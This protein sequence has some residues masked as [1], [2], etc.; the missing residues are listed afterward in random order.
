MG[1]HYN[2]SQRRV[3]GVGVEVVKLRAIR[4]EYQIPLSETIAKHIFIDATSDDV[5][6]LSQDCSQIRKMK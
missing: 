5:R 1:T 4:G 6:D 2:V 3:V